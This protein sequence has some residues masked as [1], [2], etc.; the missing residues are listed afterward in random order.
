MI[1]EFIHGITK[2]SALTQLERFGNILEREPIFPL[3]RFGQGHTATTYFIDMRAW[4]YTNTKPPCYMLAED[5]KM[6]VT[7]T[8]T[9]L[10]NI[11]A[12]VGLLV[13]DGLKD[14]S[15]HLSTSFWVLVDIL[16]ESKDIWFYH[17]DNLAD[18]E[19]DINHQV[20][21][22][23]L[24]QDK[25]SSVPSARG[26]GGGGGGG[27]NLHTSTDPLRFNI[28]RLDLTWDE[29]VRSNMPEDLRRT[30]ITQGIAQ[31]ARSAGVVLKIMPTRN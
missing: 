2:A 17:A 5:M 3:A 11:V 18:F 20:C 28:A 13:R 4:E 21:A 6:P 9:A 29:L 31:S 23:F 25:D 12:C 27:G 1:I 26:G 14:K 22:D 19:F 15:R 16:S 24:P 30:R 8:T 7:H 10:P